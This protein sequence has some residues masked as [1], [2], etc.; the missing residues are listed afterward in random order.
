MVLYPFYGYRKIT[1]VLRREG[2]LVNHKKVFRLMGEM[3]LSAIFPRANKNKWIKANQS[4][5]PYLLKDLAIEKTNQVWATDITYI[6]IHSGFVYFLAL[7]QFV[8]D[9]PWYLKENRQMSSQLL[10][11]G[12]FSPFGE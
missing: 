7:A 8:L 9:N 1:A 12:T 6:R 11:F 10:I 4:Q 5:Y 2:F 3:N